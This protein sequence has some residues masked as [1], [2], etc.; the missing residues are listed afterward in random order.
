MPVTT[1]ISS[2]GLL[3]A[4]LGVFCGIP[5]VVRLVRDPDAT[6]LSYP[7]AVLGAL[8]SATWLSYGVA[9]RDPAQLVANVPGIVCAV[10]TVVLAAKRLGLPLRTAAYAAAGWAPLVAAAFALGGVVVV[11]VLGTTVSLVKMLPQILTVVRRDPVHGLAPATFVLTQVSA[12][13]W[14]AYGLATGQWS[15]VVCSA[16]TVVLAG[17]VLSRRCPPLAVA[18]ALHEGRFGV[19]GQLLVRPFVLARRAGLTLAA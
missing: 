7:S 11:G 6:G 1:L 5:Q 13:L 15:V 2:L 14:T 8:A 18:R 9:L 4:G 12:T 16:V 19:P 3:A 17:I 10:L